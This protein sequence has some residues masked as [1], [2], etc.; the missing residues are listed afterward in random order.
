MKK[1][2]ILAFSV[3][4]I[5]NTAKT[6]TIHQLETKL[7]AG[8]LALR[9]KSMSPLMY[10]G[11]NFSG[12][13]AYSKQTDKKTVFFQFNHHRA[14]I[15]NQFGNSSVFRGFALKNH[16]LYNLNDEQGG[17]AW[18]WSNNNYF[19]YYQ[20]QGFGNFSERSNYFTTFGLAGQYKKHFNLFGRDFDFT[21]PVDIQL[22]GFYLRPSYVSNSP[23]GYL[24]PD[25]SGFGAW[26]KSIEALLPHR[27]WNFGLSP[28]LSL[29]LKSGNSISIS[30]QYEFFRINNPQP[31]SQSSGVWFVSLTTRL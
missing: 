13:I 9:D 24:Y 29:L 23:E 19:N 30:Y 6:Q 1:I 4:I 26:Y 14:A 27:A 21:V 28:N 11:S 10:S 16:N 17:F 2:V 20:N 31:I 25:N 22:V 12:A 15:S 8:G 3:L 5:T 7:G 18:G